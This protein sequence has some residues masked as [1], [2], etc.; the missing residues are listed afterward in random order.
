ML[1]PL[2]LNLRRI[3]SHCF[4]RRRKC[5]TPVGDLLNVQ[6][7]FCRRTVRGLPGWKPNSS[8][9][10][11]GFGERSM[12]YIL[13]FLCV[14]VLALVITWRSMIWMP[15]KPFHGVPSALDATEAQVRD[16]LQQTSGFTVVFRVAFHRF[17]V[18]GVRNSEA[19]VISLGTLR[20]MARRGSGATRNSTRSW[21]SPDTKEPVS[22]VISRSRVPSFIFFVFHRQVRRRVEKY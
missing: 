17:S 14:V 20:P 1:P 7:G 12:V 10:A 4:H 11:T 16:T 8:W 19:D 22:A 21:T 2:E 18:F 9:S 5:S 13:A 3:D 15:E 6:T